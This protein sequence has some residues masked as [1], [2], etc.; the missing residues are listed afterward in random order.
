MMI[1]IAILAL[2]QLIIILTIPG[3]LKKLQKGVNNN[4]QWGKVINDFQKKHSQKRTESND[5][6]AKG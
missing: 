2:V 4:S 5:K 6:Q 3:K 1:I